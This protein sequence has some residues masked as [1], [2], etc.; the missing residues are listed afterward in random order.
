MKKHK[1]RKWRK[2]FA[3]LIRKSRMLREKKNERKLQELIEL[4]R[5]RTEAW[6][7]AEKVQ[8]RLQF[9]RRSG[10]FVDI[11]ATRG[12]LKRE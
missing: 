12:G 2:K 11:L 1:R 10:Y 4:W 8:Q 6:D 7:P 3:S 5:S 9:A